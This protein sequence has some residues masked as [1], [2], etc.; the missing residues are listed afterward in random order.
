MKCPLLY[1]S[2]PRMYLNGNYDIFYSKIITCDFQ[3]KHESQCIKNRP[4]YKIRMPVINYTIK[5]DRENII[6]QY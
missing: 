4:T 6:Y 5:E 2:H 1:I 3:R